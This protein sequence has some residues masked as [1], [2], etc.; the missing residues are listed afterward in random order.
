MQKVQ[1]NLKFENYKIFLESTQL[2]IIMKYLERR[3]L[4]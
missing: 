1:K 3:K 4:T 2:D